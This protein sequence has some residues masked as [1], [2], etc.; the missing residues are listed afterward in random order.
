MR[1]CGALGAL[2]L[3]AV[4]L[5]GCAKPPEPE[6]PSY[7][8]NLTVWAAP[9]VAG[10]PLSKPEG[11]WFEERAKAFTAAHSDV[12]VTVRLFG[13]PA[14]LEKALLA[15]GERPDLA[16]GRFLPELAPHLGDVSEVIGP[17]GSE[18]YHPGSVAAFSRGGKFQGLPVVLEL[19]VLAMNEQAFA[20][21]GLPLP[22][23]GKWDYAGFENSLRVLSAKGRYGL[24][25]FHLPGYHEWW[26][27]ASGIIGQDG[28]TAPGAEEGLLRLA[29][30]RL[31]GW[32]YPDTGKL[33][34][35]DTWAAFA[36][37]PAKFAVLPVSSW[38]LPTLRSAPYN[39]AFTVAGFP[40]GVSTGYSY[41]F[42]PFSQQD[43]LKY[44]AA[45]GLAQFMAA[46]DQQVRLARETGLMP[47]LSAAANP[48]EG[49]PHLSR[50]FQFA[51]TFRPLPAGPVW[52]KAEPAVSR[53]LLYGVLGAREPR[54]VLGGVE[55]AMTEAASPASK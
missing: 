24:G 22:E 41:G 48:F 16:F 5:V 12:Q 13:S 44:Q 49:D 43:P 32:L 25:F 3:L 4:A 11:F 36:A 46:P 37:K 20:E 1:L 51:A 2:L 7:K 38:A 53:E 21:A 15:G 26:P 9:G 19:P 27:L 18:A 30:Y 14:E 54:T 52:D 47:A 17:K 29:R 8:G 55:K 45:V 34:A 33:P 35:H 50:A 39:A 40:G 42:L 10:L 31:E 23:G 6:K 28:K